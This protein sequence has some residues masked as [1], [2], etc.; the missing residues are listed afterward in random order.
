MPLG[1][2]AHTLPS[3]KTTLA[4]GVAGRVL[5]S[6]TPTSGGGEPLQI[7]QIQDL[8]IAAD[9]SPW[10]AARAGLGNAFE[11]GV[12][13]TTRAIRI[14]G[15]RAFG[16]D[17]LALSIGIGASALMAARPAG[18]PDANGVYGGGFDVPIL[19][20]WRSSADLY[21]AWIGPRVG[22]E[23]FSGVLGTTTSNATTSVSGRHLSMGGTAGLR[24]GLRHVYAVAE[25]HL[26][27][28]L[29]EG[30]L[31]ASDGVTSRVTFVG[32]TGFSVTP[33]GALVVS[34]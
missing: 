34:F 23:L 26:A 24:A 9:M 32:L 14:D 2:P 7:Q 1:H 27:Y 30:T 3:G 5:A 18:G 17:R 28:H 13:A 25:V 20:G 16:S 29:A 19:L 10:V 8:A 6:S 21:A 22:A 11:A 33:A 31:T 4:A 15:R 12:S